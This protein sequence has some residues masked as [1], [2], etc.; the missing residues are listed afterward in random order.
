MQMGW[1]SD[2]LRLARWATRRLAGAPG[3]ARSSEGGRHASGA[4]PWSP[5]VG[6]VGDASVGRRP[7]QRN[8]KRRGAARPWGGALIAGGRRG[9]RRPG[10]AVP[11]ATRQRVK[12]GWRAR[13]EAL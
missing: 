4:A 2:R 12:G 13:G 9:G 10:E 11:L 3:D 7:W 6:A 1:R 8:G 5:A